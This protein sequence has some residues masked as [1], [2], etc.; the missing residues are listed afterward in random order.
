[1]PNI[2]CY[3]HDRI[4]LQEIEALCSAIDLRI[5]ST[6]DFSTATEWLKILSFEALIIEPF[7]IEQE[8]GTLC[9]MLWQKNPSA[10]AYMYDP[11]ERSKDRSSEYVLEGLIP[12]CSTN[13]RDRIKK[14]LE[15]AKKTSDHFLDPFRVLVVEDLDSP[16]DIICSYIESFGFGTVDGVSSAK[17]ALTAL[18]SKSGY[19]SCIV[20]DVKMPEVTGKEL[21][22]L[23]RRHSQLQHLPIVVL[24]AYGTIDC[25]IDCLKAGASGFLVKPPK[26]RDLLKEISRAMRISRNKESPR[27]TSQ[28]EAELVRNM[29]EQK[30]ISV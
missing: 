8:R 12:I 2:L 5:K 30:G 19:Y 20:T 22:E 4:V 6:V 15:H 13:S 27:L 1:M 17:E 3:C 23:V 25:L 28:E 14:I 21:I 26:R 18:E 24:T 16:R 11:T 10:S 7:V 9:E 29:L